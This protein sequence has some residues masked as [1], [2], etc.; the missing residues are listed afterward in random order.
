[1]LF[2][3]HEKFISGSRVDRLTRALL[4]MLE[5]GATLLDVGCGDGKLAVQ[6]KNE[7]KLGAV[8][9][10]DVMHRK[11]EYIETML[12]DG[13]SIPFS[14]ASYDYAMLVDVLH[15]ADHQ[16]DLLSEAARVARRGVVIKDHLRN[17]LFAQTRLSFMDWVGNRRF[18]VALPHNYLSRAEWVSLYEK[19]GLRVV[20]EQTELDLYGFPVDLVFENGLHFIAV[21]GK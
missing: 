3:L 20:K 10:I 18:D 17:G 13:R 15:H 1:M 4:P 21:L 2:W 9:G 7:A 11:Q 12:F 16:Q 19:C 6:L 8:Q 5:P 14:D